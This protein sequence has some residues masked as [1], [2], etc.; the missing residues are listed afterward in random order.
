MVSDRSPVGTGLRELSRRKS[1]RRASR[2]AISS[3][4]SA[5]SPAAGKEKRKETGFGEEK[6][7]KLE[8]LFRG[9]KGRKHLRSFAKKRGQGTGEVG[10]V[11]WLQSGRVGRS[12]HSLCYTRS[13]SVRPSV[14]AP[15]GC[16]H[17]LSTFPFFFE[18]SGV[19]SCVHSGGGRASFPVPPS[20]SWPSVRSYGGVS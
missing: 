20:I 7:E 13:P 6:K 11:L 8:N 15:E 19:P 1:L 3:A 2:A 10:D 5:D 14:L 9:R 17:F 4:I 16:P 18:G 12:L